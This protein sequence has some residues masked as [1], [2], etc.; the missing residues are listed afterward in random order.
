MSES[1]SNNKRIAKNTLLLYFRTFLLMAITLYT[2]RVVL[3]TLGVDDYGIYNVVG[4]FVAMF[5]VISGALSSAI[6]RFITFELGHG[7]KDK[8]SRIFSTSVNIQILLGILIL[9]LGETVGIWFLNNR[10]NIPI[11]RMTAANWVLQCSLIS[12]T[13]NL[14]SVPYNAAI[15]AH[16][17]MKAFAYVSI[18]EAVLK[19]AIVY[20]L[21]V[22]DTDKLILY[23]ILHVFVALS[24]RL[25][26]GIYCN[27]NFSE[28]RYHLVYDKSL[29]K[30]M[31][32]FAGWNFLTNGAYILNTQG[33]NLLINIFFGV[34][35][36]AAR[37]IVAQIDS[38]IMQ[39]VNSFTTAI[40]PQIIKSYAAGDKES[41]FKLVCLGAKFSYF[42]LLIFAL[43]ILL[44]AECILALWL[45]NVPE[46]TDDF[47]RL[48]II[49][50]M[51]NMLG[52]SG[53]TACMATGKIRNYVI[54][55]SS[56]ALLVLP[57]SWIA[58]DVGLPPESTYVAYIVVY[59]VVD[60]VRLYIMRN[61]LG[62]PPMLFVKEVFI[63]IGVTTLFASVIPIVF[64]SFAPT[65]FLRLLC[66]VV[67]CLLS[68]TSGIYLF[69][70]TSTEKRILTD[71]VLIT[72]KKTKKRNKSKI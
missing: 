62:F 55:I 36:N 43:P 44:E 70:L 7:D 14:I 63:K 8:L 20:L 22:S 35:I 66:T 19:L 26:Y 52:N 47:L 13:I 53:Y 21:L 23:A 65:S 71:K 39:F 37:G 67:V 27:R 28:C 59:I 29:L 38:A 1:S 24:I 25:V 12:F 49:G 61:M 4:G 72:I 17:K 64:I 10:M 2:S 33:V 60:I 18:L 32:G 48:S 40:N 34:A 57:L 54:G 56:V 30:E 6:S 68:S 31:S 50:V 58:F 45:G 11:E 41:M 5:S 51:L 42:L 9:I 69:G 3:A 46:H 16:E 15:I